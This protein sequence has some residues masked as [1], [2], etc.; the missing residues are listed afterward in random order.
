MKNYIQPNTQSTEVAL[1]TVICGS[2]TLEIQDGTSSSGGGM[3][4]LRYFSGQ[5]QSL[6]YLI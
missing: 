3:S 1:L 4:P 2:I 5:K 6:K